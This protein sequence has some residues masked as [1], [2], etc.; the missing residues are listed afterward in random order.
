MGSKGPLDDKATTA[1]LLCQPLRSDLAP[2]S[3]NTRSCS[4][5]SILSKQIGHGN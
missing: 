4:S 2:R 1:L 3:I 5:A